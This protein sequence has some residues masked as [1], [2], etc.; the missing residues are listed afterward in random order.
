MFEYIL[1]LLGLGRELHN[2]AED[3]KIRAAGLLAK[4]EA[5]LIES[6]SI[7]DAESVRLRHLALAVSFPPEKALTALAAMRGQCDAIQQ[8]V[9]Q[10]RE[11]L[12]KLGANTRLIMELERWAGTC[13]AIPAHISTTVRQ[14]EGVLRSGAGN[15][16]A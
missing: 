3:Q 9:D 14:I 8:Q 15:G 6:R 5:S 7:L 13:S 16:E 1:G 4:V 12:N 10:S 11:M 2:R